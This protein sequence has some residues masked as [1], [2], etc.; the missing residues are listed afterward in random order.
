MF[1]WELPP[2]TVFTNALNQN[3]KYFAPFLISDF[4]PLPVSQL[5]L[6]AVVGDEESTKLY[7]DMVT[8][9]MI[10]FLMCTV[11]TVHCRQYTH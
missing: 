4:L 3:L 10:H 2:L 6:I 1:L 9:Y 7:S 11:Y 5:Q 8:V